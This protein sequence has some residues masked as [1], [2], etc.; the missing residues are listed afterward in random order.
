[1]KKLKNKSW[2][3]YFVWNR[4]LQKKKFSR[5]NVVTQGGKYMEKFKLII[6]GVEKSNKLLAIFG[7]FLTSIVI[8]GKS[9]IS[10]KE[11]QES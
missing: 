4:D 5:Y 9:I 7:T 11:D 3:F 2:V 10:L 8:I 1:M 6:K